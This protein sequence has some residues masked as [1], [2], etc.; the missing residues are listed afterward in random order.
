MSDFKQQWMTESY[1]AMVLAPDRERSF[2]E[3]F[4]LAHGALAGSWSRGA[5][6]RVARIP[7]RTQPNMLARRSLAL[8]S[9]ITG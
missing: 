1:M 4:A 8:I 7:S 9:G 2:A 3:R 6:R 5:P